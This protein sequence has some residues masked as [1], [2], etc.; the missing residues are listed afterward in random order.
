MC[1][2]LLGKNPFGEVLA[3]DIA[4]DITDAKW[5]K[6]NGWTSLGNDPA[7]ARA[8]AAEGKLVIGGAT[9]TALG[10]G[11]GHVVV[12]E[13][14]KDLWMGYP[15]VASGSREQTQR[16]PSVGM[17]QVFRRADIPKVFYAAKEI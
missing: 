10:Q 5:L 9:G 2:Q 3:D 4:K 17:T 8:A 13:N 11:H 7:A 1:T 6:R 12:V 15:Y 14:S 16:S